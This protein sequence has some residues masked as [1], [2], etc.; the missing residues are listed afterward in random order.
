[1]NLALTGDL[2]IEEDLLLSLLNTTPVVDGTPT[3][4][5]NAEKDAVAWCLD[6]GDPESVDEVR[7]LRRLRDLLQLVGRGQVEPTRI[8][9]ALASIAVVPYL[10]AEGQ[11]AWRLGADVHTTVAARALLGW[12]SLASQP[13]RLK[14]CANDECHLFLIDRSKSGTA[15]WCSMA[16]CGNR[17][18]ARRFNQRPSTSGP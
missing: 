15:K 16:A 2:R 13:G 10:S 17:M 12:L 18:K 11:P 8:N 4:L 7:E 6:V 5:L 9:G 3:D 14:A 1:M